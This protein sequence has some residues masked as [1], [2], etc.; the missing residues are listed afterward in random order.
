MNPLCSY[1]KDLEDPLKKIKFKEVDEIFSDLVDLLKV[2]E[3][4]NFG[5]K[6]L[7]RTNEY[8]EQAIVRQPFI[9]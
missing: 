1:F 2:K 8:I 7:G 3:K 4:S 6:H 9:E 5:A